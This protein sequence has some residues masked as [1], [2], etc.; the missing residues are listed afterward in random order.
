MLRSLRTGLEHEALVSYAAVA[1]GVRTRRV[2]ASA[3]LGPDAALVAY[4]HVPGRALDLLAD[5]E[6]TEELLADVWAQFKLLQTR[7]ISHR[8]LVPAAVLV[9]E[10]GAVH[11]VDLADGDIAAS[12]LVLRADT[13]QLLTTLALRTGAERA[14]GS[15]V[16]VLGPAA[17]GAALP[18]LQPIALARQTRA[19]LKQQPELLEAIRAE[20]LRTRPQAAVRAVRLERLRPR[21]LLAVVGGVVAG[22]LLLPQF[23][24]TDH[25]PIATLVEAPTRAG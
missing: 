24:T 12:D 13:A 8:A 25:N 16:A 6:L 9:A 15:A 11:L 4:E 23:F 21:T 2:V 1:A 22:C 10:C 20:V 17:V 7:R 14:V 3:E 5:E 19:A 18:L